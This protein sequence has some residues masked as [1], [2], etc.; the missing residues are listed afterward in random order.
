MEIQNLKK[1]NSQNSLKIKKLEN[2]NFQMN[3]KNQ[4]LEQ[5]I[6]TLENEITYLSN[7]NEEIKQNNKKEITNL[8]NEQKKILKICMD[9]IKELKK[10]VGY[11]EDNISQLYELYQNLVDQVNLFIADYGINNMNIDDENYLITFS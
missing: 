4:S 10:Y 9:N 7:L 2:D 6:R 3:T 11:L 8:K 5:R 1:I